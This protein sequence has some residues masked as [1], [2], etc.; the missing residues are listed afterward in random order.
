MVKPSTLWRLKSIQHLV[1]RFRGWNHLLTSKNASSAS[2]QS[3]LEKKC[4]RA[5]SFLSPKMLMQAEMKVT[6][7][8]KR[9]WLNKAFLFLKGAK[10]FWRRNLKRNWV[11]WDDQKWVLV[12]YSDVSWPQNPKRAP[13]CKNELSFWMKAGQRGLKR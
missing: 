9:T 8:T 7:R 6:A 10:H 4:R 2:Q 1:F 5:C 12:S 3:N 13:L 11:S